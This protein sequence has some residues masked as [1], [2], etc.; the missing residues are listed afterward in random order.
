MTDT[1]HA[2]DEQA[3][4]DLD[5]AW[6]EAATRHDLDAIVA[7]YAPNGSLVW[8]G[9][10]AV[11]GTADI[12]LAWKQMIDTTPG[13]GLRFAADS[14]TVASAG[15]LAADFGVVYL[16]MD[17]PDGTKVNDAAKYVVTWQKLDGKWKVLYD[18]W[19]ENQKSS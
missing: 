12:R 9:M 4:R 15:D 16:T 6:G 2:A 10:P 14:I 1:P 13:L 8:P 17:A 18:S 19:N 3:I 11:H 5:E 7:F